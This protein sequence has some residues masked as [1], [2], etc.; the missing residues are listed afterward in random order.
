MNNSGGPEDT[1]SAVATPSGEGGI[2]IIR[3]SG[4]D[5]IRIAS[6][7]VAL[8]SRLPL[9]RMDSHRLYLAD[10]LDV[11]T[12]LPPHLLSSSHTPIDEALVVYMRGPHSYTAEDVLEIHAHG[13]QAVLARILEISLQSGCRLASPGEFT[14]RA[15]LN[16]RLDLSQAEGVLDTIKATSGQSLAVAQR[17]LRGD[18]K[19][20]VDTLRAG[21]LAMLAHLEAGID[22]V[23][24]DIE[25]VRREELRMAL[26]DTAA[27]IEAALN[28]SRTGRLLREGARVVIVG[29]PNVGKSSLLNRLLGESRAIVSNTPGTTRDLIE[30]MVRFDG[31][32]LSLTD[33]AGLRETTD[34]VE[35]EGIRRTN[36]AIHDADLLIVLVDASEIHQSAQAIDVSTFASKNFIVVLN[37]IDLLSPKQLSQLLFDLSLPE[38]IRA[39]PISTLTGEGLGTLRDTIRQRTGLLTME[40]L[41]GVMITNVRHQEILLRCRD[42]LNKALD[43]IDSG[44]HSECVAVDLRGAADALG[45]ITGAI[46]SD[47]IL[48]R[49]FSE[50]CIGK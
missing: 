49:I 2:G 50:F 22:F 23:E 3:M 36:D 37:K 43:S 39:L 44:N 5:T 38:S 40:P 13:S 47:D 35:R 21:L 19:R 31:C 42:Y 11:P 6:R 15:F 10:I 26:A 48:T 24:E 18:L 17:H 9:I 28:S 46:T 27:V 34:D 4:P 45:E 25:F 41:Q 30:E 32:T 16:G 7:F 14:K 12:V 1:I 29:R 20:E 33:T 8:R